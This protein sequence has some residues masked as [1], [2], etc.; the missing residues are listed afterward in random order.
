[1]RV[2]T[3]YLEHSE[4]SMQTQ[5]DNGCL[6]IQGQEYPDMRKTVMRQQRGSRNQVKKKNSKRKS[7]RKAKGMGE[8]SE[9][10]IFFNEF[11]TVLKKRE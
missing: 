11:R 10:E 5:A 7:K 1:M 4:N 9:K 6:G 8:G 3:E 2:K